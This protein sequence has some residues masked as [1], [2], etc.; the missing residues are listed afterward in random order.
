MWFTSFSVAEGTS[1]GGVAHLPMAVPN[2]WSPTFHPP[3]QFAPTSTT[4]PATSLAG[5]YGAVA[6]ARDSCQRG[7][8]GNL[9]S[10]A[11]WVVPARVIRV[12]TATLYWI[13]LSAQRQRPSLATGVRFLL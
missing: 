4:T 11:V 9:R 13:C 6:C 2:A 1:I 8:L 5:T 3:W 12:P 10:V 7:V